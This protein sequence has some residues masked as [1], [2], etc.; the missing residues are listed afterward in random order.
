MVVVRDTQGNRIPTPDSW[1]S[2]S[3]A[4]FQRIVNE[5]EP[6]KALKDRSRI[7][8]FALMINRDPEPIAE[9]TDQ[10][11][12]EALFECTRFVYEDPLD[13]NKLPMPEAITIAG[14]TVE[15]PRELGRMAIGQNIHVRAELE[16]GALAIDSQGTP[17]ARQVSRVT[18]IYLQPYLDGIRKDDAIQKA[19]F[20]FNR[21][22]KIEEEL[23]TM[24]ITTVY[25]VGF[26]LLKRQRS[27]GTTWRRSWLRKIL[28]RIAYALPLQSWRKLTSSVTLPFHSLNSSPSSSASTPT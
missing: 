13:F 28:M 21:V 15:I 11:L 20:D 4:I 3:T 2:C 6:T 14:R 24:P 22:L 16:A 26:F 19:P 23:L 18:A 1:A 12:E 27:Y 8:L 5:W 10:D 25:P 17:R 9:S 7:T